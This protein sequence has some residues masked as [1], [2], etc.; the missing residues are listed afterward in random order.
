MDIFEPYLCDESVKADYMI[1]HLSRFALKY[2]LTPFAYYLVRA[3]PN[4][5]AR[6]S[7]VGI[8]PYMFLRVW[9]AKSLKIHG[10]ILNST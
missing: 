8:A 6:W 5:S 4:R 2:G 3:Y 1:K 7:Y 9:I 10:K